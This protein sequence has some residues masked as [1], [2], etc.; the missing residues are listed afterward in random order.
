[1]SGEP[2]VIRHRL[3]PITT[4]LLTARF[5]KT[6]IGSLPLQLNQ[7][8]KNQRLRLIVAAGLFVA[9][10]GFL[11]FLAATTTR[12]VIL[13]R[14]QFL[15]SEVDIIAQVNQGPHGPDPQ[16]IV[17]QVYWPPPE[18]DKLKGKQIVIKNLPMIEKHDGWVGAG[19]YILPLR[20]NNG[21]SFEVVP[22]P[23]SPGFEPL[24]SRTRIYRETSETLR[25][26]QE[27][28]ASKR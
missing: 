7:S 14:S 20:K 27:I 3:R 2:E 6:K 10:I 19:R 16:V 22:L 12:P 15:V 13:S 18:N 1:V 21:D 9:W 26:L 24:K 8:W 5:S 11:A 25:Q 23:M 28:E 4:H 17:D